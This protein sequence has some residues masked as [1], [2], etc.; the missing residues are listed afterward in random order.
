MLCRWS[1]V[2]VGQ[3]TLRAAGEGQDTR[4]CSGLVVAWRFHPCVRSLL[5]ESET[6]QTK[7]IKYQTENRQQDACRLFRGI[8]G[9]YATEI[10]KLS[11]PE[12]FR[13]TM[14][15]IL[16]LFNALNLLEAA[17]QHLKKQRREKSHH[18]PLI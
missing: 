4:R 3:K 10:L 13:L 9:R 17:H 11:V 14:Q 18:S 8:P 12:D 15:S 2:E 5:H 16:V 1:R 6:T 7:V